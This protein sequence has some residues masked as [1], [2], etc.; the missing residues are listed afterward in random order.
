M[1]NA[2]P[3]APGLVGGNA[4]HLTIGGTIPGNA[5]DLITSPT[6]SLLKPSTSPT[7]LVNNTPGAIL[8][9]R[10][11][12]SG[13]RWGQAGY[14]QITSVDL[15]PWPFQD[16]IK[17]VFREVNNVPPGNSPVFND[18]TR[19]FAAT[20]TALYGGAITISSYIWEY[21]GAPCPQ[22]VCI[23]YTVTPSASA[24]GTI[25]PAMPQTVR[26]GLTMTFNVVP[27]SD[28]YA[29]MGGTCGG[30]LSGTTYTTNVIS[31]ACTVI[32]TFQ[33][34][35]SAILTWDPVVDANLTG[36]RVYYGTA[37]GTYFQSLGSGISV[38]NATTYTVPGLAG[39]TR[40]YFVVTSLNDTG[41][42]SRYSNEV[43]K[44]TP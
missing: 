33:P 13:T 10:Y 32:A 3:S 36:Y 1:R 23:T 11:G 5:V 31:G 16:V 39:G 6:V 38:G 24:N 18:T 20:G 8:L 2:L 29:S 41:F 40:Y 4:D 19:G 21:L 42:E 22:T 9:K 43:S 35:T 27:N 25:S 30:T 17:S 12:A 37:S 14:D 44:L 26:P 7:N 28:F 34:A 15:W